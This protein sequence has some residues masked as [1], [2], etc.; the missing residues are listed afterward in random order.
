MVKD[1]IMKIKKSKSK[2]E[3]HDLS[4]KKAI[5]GDEQDD[6]KATNG[7]KEQDKK[8]KQP[9]KHEKEK[10]KL[11]DIE[12]PTKK[13]NTISINDNTSLTN[14]P[15]ANRSPDLTKNKDA[16]NNQEHSSSHTSTKDTLMVRLRSASTHINSVFSLLHIPK[17]KNA[18]ADDSEDDEG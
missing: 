16:V 11:N 14:I 8:V 12:Q 18:G 3:F 2:A 10:R 1:R 5:N 13:E 9:K 17:H 7:S 6:Q 4:S 15:P